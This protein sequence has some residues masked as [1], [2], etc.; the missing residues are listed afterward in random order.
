MTD[1]E[2]AAF[3]T[4]FDLA[5]PPGSEEADALA[6]AKEVLPVE[7]VQLRVAVSKD[8]AEAFLAEVEPLP[9]TSRLWDLPNVIITPHVAGQS[10]RR[11]DDMTDFFCENL[12]RYQT[13]EPLLNLLTDKQ[14]GFPIRQ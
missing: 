3:W 7:S 11:I 4:G 13:G 14:L 1:A 12:R 10:A 8:V 6:R 9:E 2:L 5:K